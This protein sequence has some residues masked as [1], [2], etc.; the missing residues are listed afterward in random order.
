MD[1]SRTKIIACATVIE[2][3]YPLI[4]EGMAYQVLDFGLHLSP[5]NLREMLQAAIDAACPNYDTLLLGY[6]LCSMAVIG[7]KANGCR[8]VI[9]RTDD[10]IGIFLG[11]QQAYSE[12]V[13][14]EAGTYYL[15]KGWIEVAD[16][17]FD[18]YERLVEQYEVERANRIM[19]IML[20]NY[21]RLVY[22]DTGHQDN[23]RYV[24]IARRTAEKF[25]LRFE[26]VRGSNALIAKMLRGE[27]DQDFLVVEAGKSVSYLDFKLLQ[28]KFEASSLPAAPLEP[29]EKE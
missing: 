15:T 9:P 13:R 6:G 3:M 1:I 7:L 25:N 19:S 21:K 10:C 11:S 18:E 14:K 8:L 16:T 22:I 20:K 5:P 2:E 27:W 12:Q 28:P 26:E 4:P 23:A 24:E 17:P 29:A